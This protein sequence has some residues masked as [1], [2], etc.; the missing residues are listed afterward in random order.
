VRARKSIWAPARARSAT[1]AGKAGCASSTRELQGRERWSRDGREARRA[2]SNWKGSALAVSPAAIRRGPLPLS[3]NALVGRDS[4]LRVLRPR[5]RISSSR[6]ASPTSTR[7]LTRQGFPAAASRSPVPALL[8]CRRSNSL[9][10]L[11]GLVSDRQ[12]R[13]LPP[14]H[15]AAVSPWS[16]CRAGLTYRRRFEQL[17]DFRRSGALPAGA[18]SR[19]RQGPALI[20]SW[21][22]SGRRV[23]PEFQP[24]PGPAACDHRKLRVCAVRRRPK[25][26]PSSG[27]ASPAPRR[28]R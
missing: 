7:L 19:E 4:A 15:S 21:W 16:Q 26:A 23:Q 27:P 13:R 12:A 17:R 18:P 24:P 2:L 5:P 25:F 10:R 8:S 6:G 28:G 11:P 22:V 1:A 20:S 9:K 3:R 14:A